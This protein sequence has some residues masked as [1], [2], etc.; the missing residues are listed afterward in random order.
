MITFILK[1]ISLSILLRQRHSHYHSTTSRP[2]S[3]ASAAVGRFDLVCSRPGSEAVWRVAP[4][5]R[6][7]LEAPTRAASRTNRRT[8]MTSSRTTATSCGDSDRSRSARFSS[9]T[10]DCR[11]CCSYL[12]GCSPPPES[13]CDVPNG[14]SALQCDSVCRSRPAVCL[15]ADLGM[16]LDYAAA[17]STSTSRS[18]LRCRR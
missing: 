2:R 6:L 15:P 13:G 4:A 1:I 8:A 14:F 11:R 18:P 17:R 16:R 9:D 7:A 12:F 5:W 10:L 3:P